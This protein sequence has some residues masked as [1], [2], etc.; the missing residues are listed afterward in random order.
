M[1]LRILAVGNVNEKRPDSIVVKVVE[2][3]QAALVAFPVVRLCPVV[4]DHHHHHHEDDA[5]NDDDE[6]DDEDN[7]EDEDDDQDQDQDQDQD[8]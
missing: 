5:D 3:G 6:D 1:D 8:D 4:S 7:D 2:D